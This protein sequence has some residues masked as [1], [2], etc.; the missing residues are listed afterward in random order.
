MKK[1]T[2]N[3]S[4]EGFCFFSPRERGE[5]RGKK[6]KKQKRATEIKQQ[7]RKSGFSGLEKV[8]LQSEPWKFFSSFFLLSHN[9]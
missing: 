9:F 6:S 4:E 2:K 8:R 5:G 1:R 3:N 7:N